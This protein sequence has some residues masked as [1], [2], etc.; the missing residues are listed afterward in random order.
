MYLNLYVYGMDL[1]NVEYENGGWQLYERSNTDGIYE[2]AQ[3]LAKAH[4]EDNVLLLDSSITDPDALEYDIWD[5]DPIDEAST[6][7]SSNAHCDTYGVCGGHSCP[8]YHTCM[9]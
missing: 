6:D 3:L 1:A 2:T 4:G 5:G 9:C 7:Y 8:Y